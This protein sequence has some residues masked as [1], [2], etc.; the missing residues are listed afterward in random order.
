MNALGCQSLFDTAAV[1]VMGRVEVLG[2]LPRLLKDSA[3][4]V[5]H[6]TA[7]PPD[8]FVGIDAP[9]FNLRLELSL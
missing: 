1:V 4:P 3:E 6:F 2:R 5:K 9:D 8:V 7:N